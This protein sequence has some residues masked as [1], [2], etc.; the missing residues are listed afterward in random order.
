MAGR[1][2]FRGARLVEALGHTEGVSANVTLEPWGN[3]DLP[4]LEWLMGDPHMT[5]HLGVHDLQRLAPG[6]ARPLKM[7]T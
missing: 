2:A 6:P 3:A 1:H 4:L 7:F 5:E